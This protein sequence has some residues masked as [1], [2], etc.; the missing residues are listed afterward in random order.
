MVR[1]LEFGRLLRTAL[2]SLRTKPLFGVLALR[3]PAAIA[4]EM[5]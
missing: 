1:G 2:A 5:R 3:A 4:W